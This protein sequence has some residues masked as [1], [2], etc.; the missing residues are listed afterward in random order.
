MTDTDTHPTDP[1]DRTDRT[2]RTDTP[3]IGTLLDE[4]IAVWHD[5]DPERRRAEIERLWAPDAVYA[6]GESIYRGHAQ[7]A[8]GITK[9]HDAWVATGNSFGPADRPTTTT[10]P[11]ASS[12]TCTPPMA[13]PS[14][15]S[16]PTSWASPT[17][18]GSPPTSSSSTRDPGTARFGLSRR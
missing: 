1:T 16:A 3:D 2:D 6:N 4:Y 12:G 18:F 15:R 13:P 7:I 8:A 5:T 14:S 10:A 11:S 9:S 17:T